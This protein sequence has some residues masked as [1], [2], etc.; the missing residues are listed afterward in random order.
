MSPSV[1]A[2][3]S[4]VLSIIGTVLGII[5]FVPKKNSEKYGK[6][7]KAIS[8]FINFRTLIIDYVLKGL[9]ILSSLFCFFGG[10]FTIFMVET[11]T[12][13][14][15]NSNSVFS[16]P[17]VETSMSA[18][19]VIT[20][21]LTMILGPI[22]IRLFYELIML[23]VVGVKN[24][25]E[26]NKK[27]PSCKKEEPEAPVDIKPQEPTPEEKIVEAAEDSQEL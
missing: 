21:I 9:Y 11:T 10:F 1:V 24:I 12:R 6:K 2:A 13:Q 18:N 25:I 26:I 27:M 22:I 4:V 17:R 20:G 16:E 23:A 15:Y 7:G 8:D 3:L 14:V 19:N 5:F